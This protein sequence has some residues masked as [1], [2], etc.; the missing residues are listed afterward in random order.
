MYYHH[1]LL[2]TRQYVLKVVLT[3][4][5]EIFFFLGVNAAGAWGWQPHHLHVPNVMKSGSLNLLEP[6]EPHRACYGTL[7]PLPL[8]SN[9]LLQQRICTEKKEKIVYRFCQIISS[10]IFLNWNVMSQQHC[11][12]VMLFL[13]ICSTRWYWPGRTET[14]RAL[15]TV[16]CF[17]TSVYS[18]GFFNLNIFQTLLEVPRIQW[19]RSCEWRRQL[20]DVKSSCEYLEWKAANRK[21]GVVLI[22]GGWAWC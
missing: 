7:L 8:Y 18:V 1:N 6:S 22:I 2:T 19:T 14:Y 20:T 17:L 16:W 10:F 4:Y 12:L 11:K 21:Q 5:T 9:I 3:Y 15:K 13:E